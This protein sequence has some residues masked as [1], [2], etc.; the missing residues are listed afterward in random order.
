MV[1]A[2]ATRLPSKEKTI[3]PN[4]TFIDVVRQDVRHIDD[5]YVILAAVYLILRLPIGTPAFLEEG[6]DIE[7]NLQTPH[8]LHLIG[9]R[10]PKSLTP[11]FTPEEEKIR[12]CLASAENIHLAI[13][14]LALTLGSKSMADMQYKGPVPIS[15]S[16]QKLFF[17]SQRIALQY[18]N[19]NLII[20]EDSFTAFLDSLFPFRPVGMHHNLHYYVTA[21]VL[22]SGYPRIERTQKTL[23]SLIPLP[24]TFS[25]DEDEDLAEK[26]MAEAAD[27]LFIVPVA[28]QS[29]FPEEDKEDD[30]PATTCTPASV[31]SITAIKSPKAERELTVTNPDPES[32]EPLSPTSSVTSDATLATWKRSSVSSSTSS[33]VAPEVKPSAACSAIVEEVVV[34]EIKSVSL[35]DKCMEFLTPL[36]EFID[37]MGN[38]EDM[39]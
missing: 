12:N 7:A 34:A 33:L 25:K 16:D 28:P 2:K 8:H 22:K 14:D 13:Y 4:P 23:K 37:F 1:V 35:W 3:Q 31:S 27:M 26:L 36:Y 11:S 15:P 10:E 9:L 24:A 29:E 20:Q 19:Y 5:P 17:Q 6:F 38:P 32:P 30:S 39:D 18:F 21:K